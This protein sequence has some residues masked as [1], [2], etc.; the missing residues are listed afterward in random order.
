MEANLA[1]AAVLA[2]ALVALDLLVQVDPAGLAV[3]DLLQEELCA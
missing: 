2:S 1:A 3:H